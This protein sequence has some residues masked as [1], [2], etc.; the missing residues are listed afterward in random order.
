MRAFALD[1]FGRP[2]SVHE[3][4]TPE[5]G[6]GQ[7]RVKVHAAGINPFDNAVLKG[8]MKDRMPHHFPLIPSSD[9]AGTVDAAGPGVSG[10][11]AGDH[12]FGQLGTMGIGHGSLAEYAI[13]TAGTIA[14]RPDSIDPEFGAAL[15][16]AG[17]SALQCIEPIGLKQ[18]DVVVI[19]GAAGGI[20]GFA[21]QMATHAGA[22]VVAVASK[23]NL[24][25]ARSLGAVEAIDYATGDVVEAVKES[26]PDG[27][28][29]VVHA[30]GDAET[31]GRLADLVSEGG[32]VVSMRGGAKV[33]EL[34]GRRITGI[35][36]M[37]KT[38]TEALG[39]LAAMVEAG[40][41]KRPAITT[42]KLADAGQAFEQSA[43]GHVRGKLVVVP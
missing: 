42:F 38:T 23:S 40:H 21:T 39:K 18:G 32:Y 19:L 1:E 24:D 15:P 17:V 33:D 30:S 41:L 35:N 4:P 8:M 43:S 6:D 27:I 25:Y 13:A 20:G 22:V 37:T 31:V 29:A 26:H 2:G 3:V 7:V 36:V 5:P 14:K 34:A 16:L 28:K 12:V 10:F 11:K 9:V